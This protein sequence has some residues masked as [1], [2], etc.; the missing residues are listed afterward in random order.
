MLASED[1][2]QVSPA[3]AYDRLRDTD[4]SALVD[5]R[6]R[7]EWAFVGVP[8]LRSIGRPLLTVEWVRFPDMAQNGAFLEELESQAGGTLPRTLF[9]I[10]RSGTRSMA[11]ARFVAGESANRGRPVRCTNVAEGFEGDLDGESRR[12]STN[13]WKVAGLPWRQS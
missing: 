9:F 7:A 2:D 1:V 6:S 4:E 12:G 5:V 11:A 8:D 3:E 10:C 13:G